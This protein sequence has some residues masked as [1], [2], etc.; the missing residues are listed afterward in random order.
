MVK[1]SL[2]DQ[3]KI[4]PRW[5]YDIVNHWKMRAGKEG[6]CSEVVCTVKQNRHFIAEQLF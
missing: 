2:C 5:H 1:N 6:D 3:Q 4:F